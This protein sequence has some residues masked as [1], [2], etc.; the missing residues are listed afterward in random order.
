MSRNILADAEACTAKDEI[1]RVAER[2]RAA[3]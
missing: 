3:G 1:H 2:H